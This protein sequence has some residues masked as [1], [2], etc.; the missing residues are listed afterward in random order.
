MRNMPNSKHSIEK[1]HFYLFPDDAKEIEELRSQTK[2]LKCSFFLHHW[3][4]SENNLLFCK[5]CGATN[6]GLFDLLGRMNE[7]KA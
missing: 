4:Y 1:M 2:P 3:V 5:D 7:V 6:F